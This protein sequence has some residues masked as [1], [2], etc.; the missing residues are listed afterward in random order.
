VNDV[1]NS[2]IEKLIETT[3][4]RHAQRTPKRIPFGLAR[5]QGDDLIALKTACRH[6]EFRKLIETRLPFGVRGCI[7]SPRPIRGR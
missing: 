5:E 4:S 6:G 2:D 3:G 1:S 7:A